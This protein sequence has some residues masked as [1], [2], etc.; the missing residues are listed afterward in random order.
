M[1]TIR[2]A[3]ELWRHA[4]PAVQETALADLDGPL[5]GCPPCSGD[6]D[7]GRRCPSRAAYYGAPLTDD[8]RDTLNRRWDVVE[9]VIAIAAVAI[10]AGAIVQRVIA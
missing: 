10:V 8:E 4:Q 2:N 1:T 9:A 7:Q 3:P 5:I 6:C